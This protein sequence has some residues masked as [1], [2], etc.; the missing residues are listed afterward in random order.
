MKKVFFFIAIIVGL[1][2]SFNI[3]K[4]IFAFAKSKL[5]KIECVNFE[6]H[7]ILNELNG[8][9][10]FESTPIYSTAN[11]K[12]EFLVEDFSYVDE[13]TPIARIKG[14]NEI[15]IYSNISG[16]F[17]SSICN[18]YYQSIL[19]IDDLEI[20]DLSIEKNST[21]ETVKTGQ[22]IGTII[23]NQNYLVA[24]EKDDMAFDL[25]N[26]K[27]II[28]QET[29]FK[30]EPIK[31]FEKENYIF[32]LFDSFLPELYYNNK[33]IV[34]YGEKY[35][36]KLAKEEII[37]KSGET[38]VLIV[39]GNTI[40]FI[41]ISIINSRKEIYGIP[42]DKNFSSFKYFLVVRTPKYLHEGEF[43]GGF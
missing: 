24:L 15:E 18:K 30:F 22:V 29:N 31:T 27:L 25:K 40:S 8:K 20:S 19:N 13:N 26:I 11:G 10:I 42:E 6:W 7:E 3:T 37:D 38:G 21:K 12:L 4:D 41:P 23:T 17:T 5:I 2:L 39:N 36:L 32:L 1:V 34:S 33:F 14:E 35:C 16:F 43:V 28:N 9:V